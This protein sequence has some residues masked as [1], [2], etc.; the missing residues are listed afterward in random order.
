[1]GGMRFASNKRPHSAMES[2]NKNWLGLMRADLKRF[3][4]KSEIEEVRCDAVIT[5]QLLF[6]FKRKKRCFSREEREVPLSSF[7]KTIAH[8]SK[9]DSR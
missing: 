6:L 7:P 8:E 4:S 9:A 1:M 2:V 5:F 3:L